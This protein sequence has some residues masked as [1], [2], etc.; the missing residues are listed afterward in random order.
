MHDD[1]RP[2]ACRKAL[3][4]RASILAAIRGFFAE[5]GVLEVDTP[6]L[7]GAG[8]TDPN[9]PS[10]YVAYDGP[11]APP[12]GRLWL[13]SSPEHAMKRLLAAGSGAIYQITHAFRAGERGRLHNPEFTL[14]E[15][16]RL[17]WDQ[18]ALM[19]EVADL[20][21]YLLGGCT[22]ERLT[23]TQVF[24][25][26]LGVDPLEASRQTL[27]TSAGGLGLGRAALAALD[28]D[29]LLDLLLSHRVVPALG[30]GRLTF[31]YDFPAS[32]AALA[33]LRPD[34]PR[35]AERFELFSNGVE[36]A[37]GYHEL[38]DAVEQRLRFERERAARARLG[39]PLPDVDAR[40]LAAM[41]A[42]LPPCAG[43]ALGL[44]RLIMHV[45]GAR[46]IDE[47]IAF[48]IERA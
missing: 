3:R 20:F 43:V 8:A 45:C 44:D 22:V 41:E 2:S 46:H 24:H 23:Y 37:N 4:Q 16:Y 1:W 13:Q 47:V 42:G 19:D 5:R 34:D 40:L 10:F 32:Q 18:H 14:L 17:G 6:C 39:L 38:T 30:S 36:L 11:G 28:R 12:E 25:A 27:E 35:V 15:W 33:R 9:V 21:R 7:V 26:H 31:V 29:G 48:P